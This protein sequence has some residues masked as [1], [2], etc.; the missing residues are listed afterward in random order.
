[1][2][3][4]LPIDPQPRR[5]LDLPPLVDAKQKEGIASAKEPAPAKGDPKNL[6]AGMTFEGSNGS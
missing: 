4:P 1:M 3:N 2:P 5:D 6:F